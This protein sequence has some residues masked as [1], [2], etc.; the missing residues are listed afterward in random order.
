MSSGKWYFETT[1]VTVGFLSMIGIN[2][3]LLQ[4]G[5]YYAGVSPLGYVYLS[6][7]GNKQNNSIS[8][9]YGA[10]YTT[11][12]II[13]CAF[14]ADSGSLTFYKNGVSQGVAF[15]SIPAGS[16]CF[17]VYGRTSGGSNNCAA[18]FGQRPFAYTP[19]TGYKALNTQNL[20]APSIQNGAQYMA[21]TLYT[22]NGATQTIVNANNSVSFQPDLIWGK[23]RSSAYDNTLIDSIRGV[24]KEL[25]SNSTSAEN[26][27][28]G[29][30]VTAFNSNGFALATGNQ[31][32]RSGDSYV[33]WQWKAGGTAVTN[34]AGSIT[35]SVSA[36]TTSGFSVVTYTGS[37]ASATAGH[38]LGIAPSMVIF[39]NRGSAQDWYVY[40]ASVG[41]NAYLVLNSTAAST[42]NSGWTGVSSTTF[43]LGGSGAQY[44]A[45]G[46]TYVAYCFAAIPGYSAFGSYTG[47]GSTDGPFVYCGFR[48]RYVMV[49]R[50]SN[51]EVW[52]VIDTS[53]DTYNVTSKRLLP[54]SSSAENTGDA[55]VMDILS[56][57]FKLRSTDSTQNFN[58]DTYIYAAFAENPFN[59]S[60]A[61]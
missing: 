52:A 60:L 37:G 30:N 1:I 32:N 51:A 38:G 36:N 12:D 61:R 4:P 34:T 49:K 22:G 25:F 15:S 57:G 23:D 59:Y 29:F 26:N 9:A 55:N 33:A 27:N 42:S 56:N 14:D 44:N 24:G 54:N 58:G 17:N 53:R 21:A 28:P 8:T 40:H 43:S 5:D 7:N 6:L 48:P 35:S 3:V 39:K 18:N 16:Y 50:A 45:N 20:P 47:N 10:S 41:V 19:P 13:G 11:G 2:N 31:F 46:N